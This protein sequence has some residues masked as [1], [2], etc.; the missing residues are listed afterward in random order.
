MPYLLQQVQEW[1][2]TQDFLISEA[3]K[4]FGMHIDHFKINLDLQIVL[5][6][7]F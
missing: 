7:H 1:E 4:D 6:Q 3:I 2:L 5:I